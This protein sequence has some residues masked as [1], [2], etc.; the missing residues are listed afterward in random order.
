MCRK[1]TKNPQSIFI[2]LRIFQRVKKPFD[3]LW[4]LPKKSAEPVILLSLAYVYTLESKMADN[5]KPLKT[6]LFSGASFSKLKLSFKL[7]N[8]T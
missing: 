6:R 4:R 1:T 5:R 3:T 8:L 2:R 7:M